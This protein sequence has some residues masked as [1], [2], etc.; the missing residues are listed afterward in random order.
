MLNLLLKWKPIPLVNLFTVIFT[1]YGEVCARQMRFL[2]WMKVD[3][4]YIIF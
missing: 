2:Q 1:G 4:V 3:T